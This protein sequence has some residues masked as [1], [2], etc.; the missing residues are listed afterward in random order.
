[1]AGM[2]PP[3]THAAR[4][5]SSQTLLLLPGPGFDRRIWGG[6]A[7]RLTQDFHVV[8]IDHIGQPAD[9]PPDPV[10]MAQETMGGH[11][12]PAVVAQAGG[13]A[14]AVQLARHGLARA[15]VLFH[16]TPGRQLAGSESDFHSVL[17]SR[18]VDY[19]WAPDVA[20][21]GDPTERRR[22][23]TS[24]LGP[25]LEPMRERGVAPADVERILQMFVDH[26]EAMVTAPG[27]RTAPAEDWVAG[28]EA[29]AVPVLVVAPAGESQS[30]RA[31]A[32]VADRLPRGRLTLQ[33]SAVPGLPWLPDP[34]GVA[35][36]VVA[37]L[38]S[39]G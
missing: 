32:A 10:A 29:V 39:C 26:L 22:V 14:A 18:L 5:G 20:T 4:G 28:L 16:P 23:W 27:R 8:H 11:G 38:R 1:M 12:I 7:D 35:R 19:E 24:H 31:A 37:F 33:E 21:L 9:E 34:D 2:T 25:M 15:A 36:D 17:A 30:G 6:F 13:A 3:D